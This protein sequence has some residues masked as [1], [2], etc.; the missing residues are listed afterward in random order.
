MCNKDENWTFLT[1]K[2]NP[3]KLELFDLENNNEGLESSRRN[4]MHDAILLGNIW[5]LINIE[6]FVKMGQTWS[7]RAL[8]LPLE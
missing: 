7:F 5:P 2:K 1:L 3:N 6:K 4:Y 8:K